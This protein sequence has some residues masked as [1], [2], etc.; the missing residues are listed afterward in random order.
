MLHYLK[1]EIDHQD[2]DTI[3]DPKTGHTLYKLAELK[4]DI[5]Q[6][7]LTKVPEMKIDSSGYIPNKGDK[8]YFLPGCSVPRV[9]MKDLTL[10]HGIKAVRDIDDANII[11]GSKD[12]VS[13][14][15]RGTWEY[16][17]PV[18][19]FKEFV[20]IHRDKL[21]D[22]VID[23]IESALE[24]YTLDGLVCNWATVRYFTDDD[25]THYESLKANPTWENFNSNTSEYFT[26]IEDEHKHTYDKL[27]NKNI[28]SEA[29][30]LEH[31]NGPDSVVIDNEMFNQL[32]TMFDSSDEDNHILAMEIMA[33]SNYKPSLLYLEM[34]FCNY[35][36][37]MYNS[38]TKN[39]VNFKSLI[40]Y[41]GKQ[42]S[43]TTDID[44]IIK[45]LA[46]HN[47]LTSD[48]IDIILD[49]YKGEIIRRGDQD[50]FKVKE[51]TLSEEMLKILNEPYVYKLIEF[52][53]PEV[54]LDEPVLGVADEI[55]MVNEDIETKVEETEAVSE[56]IQSEESPEVLEAE[57]NNSQIEEKNESDGFEWF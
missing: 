33:N 23:N 16:L 51:V 52:E 26:I 41:V 42:S 45:S 35:C 20:D 21:D 9:K 53:E 44:D 56:I 15:T 47:V 50:H 29:C 22:Y 40:S 48:K 36:N 24:F 19:L 49:N 38:R 3:T 32:S 57:S 18:E 5:K 34:L 4:I 7:Y 13:K 46:R 27:I 54:I 43:L 8:L 11:V 31:L 1:I 39:H 2:S 6:T 25:Y 17:V 37:K 12:T 10:Q 30:I 55:E 14:M 28:I